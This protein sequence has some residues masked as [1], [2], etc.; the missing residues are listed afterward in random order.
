MFMVLDKVAMIPHSGMRLHNYGIE[1]MLKSL[2]PRIPHHGFRFVL[3]MVGLYLCFKQERS[4]E[5]NH[6]MIQQ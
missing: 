2:K 1:T 4:E 6:Y 3:Q 5:A